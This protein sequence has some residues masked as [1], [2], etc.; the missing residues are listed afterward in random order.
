MSTSARMIV[1]LTCVGLV[2]GG[3]LA[4]V[5]IL[6]KDRIAMNKQK[7]IEEAILLVLPGTETSAVVFDREDL[8]IY[9]G[10]DSAQSPTGYA[11]LTRGTG[12]QDIITLMLGMDAD[13]VR[14]R[15]LA[16]LEQ[17]ETPGLGAKI[18]SQESFLQFWED[19]DA[20]GPLSLRKPAA[21]SREELAAN[22][23]NTITGA[24]ISSQ[25]VL[26]IVNSAVAEAKALKQDG[27]L[28][29]EVS[30]GN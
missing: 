21:G 15:R 14:I 29:K 28:E 19:K 16:V 24:T 17:K 26:D 5:G 23:V 30:D 11:V 4:G 3:I 8:T 27:A 7:E 25:K 2:S 10:K 9:E 22:E 13:L 20:S 6:T 1:V 18:M 12:F